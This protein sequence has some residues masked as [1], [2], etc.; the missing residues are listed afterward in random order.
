MNRQM[1]ENVKVIINQAYRYYI[2]N[3][4]EHQKYSNAKSFLNFIRNK[5]NISDL[6][7]QVTTLDHTVAE[8]SKS[9]E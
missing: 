4:R 5:R 9:T 6:S 3:R 1:R 8:N 7:N 2:R